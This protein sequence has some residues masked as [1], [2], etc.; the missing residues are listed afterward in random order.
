ML[1]VL[2]ELFD[3]LCLPVVVSEMWMLVLACTLPL[4]AGYFMPVFI[5]GEC[6]DH[7]VTVGTTSVSHSSPPI[8]RL[9]PNMAELLEENVSYWCGLAPLSQG[10]LW[11]V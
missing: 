2:V 8:K 3:I 7:V 10:Q 11:A 6:A 4:P 5:Y 1:H 9:V